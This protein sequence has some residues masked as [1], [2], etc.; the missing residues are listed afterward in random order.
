M[1]CLGATG[2]LGNGIPAAS[3]ANGVA[4]KPHYIGADMGS[5]DP[6]PYYL[7]SGRAST[8]E[9]PVRRDLGLVIT[10]GAQLGVPV[11]IG[12]AGTAGAAP[13]LEW[14]RSLLVDVAKS[15][16]LRLRLATIHSDIDADWLAGRLAAGRVSS[17]GLSPELTLDDVMSATRI[18]AQMGVEPYIEAIENGADIVLAGRSTDNA[19]F[20]SVPTMQ[21]YDRGLATHMAQLLECSSL[22]AEPGGRDAI[23][24]ELHDNYFLIESM[25]PDRRCTPSSVAAHC[26]YE[27]GNP[28]RVGQ[29][30]GTLDLGS[31]VFEDYD[32]RRTKVSGSRWIPAEKYAVKCEGVRKA[33]YRAIALG[34]VRDPIMLAQLDEV[35]AVVAGI[36]AELVSDFAPLGSYHLAFRTYGRSGVLGR[37]EPAPLPVPHEAFIVTDVVAESP[38]TA[39]AICAVAK[40]NLLHYFYPGIL[41]TGA[42]LAIPFS[43]DVIEVGETYEFCVYHLAEVDPTDHL[44]PISYEKIG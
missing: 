39:H 2:G 24:G 20:S 44:F 38:G 27:Q 28:F 8:G 5:I 12:S 11:L 18:V 3:F 42:N 41:A 35:N 17:C 15:K 34:A 22:S 19:V 10:A 21:G 25:H 13:H 36:V 29:P 33:G 30:G 26:L 6:G 9:L 32:E 1:R 23:F 43:P 7:G 40:Q 4:R 14:T 16:G 31:A 37:A